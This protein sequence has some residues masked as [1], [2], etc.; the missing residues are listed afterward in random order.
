MKNVCFGFMLLCVAVNTNA[1]FGELQLIDDV[2]FQ[3]SIVFASDLD[4][5]SDM[6][7]LI[8]G[9]NANTVAWYENLDGEGTFGEIQYIDQNLFFT[10]SL[11]TADFDG[12]GDMDVLASSRGDDKVVWYENLDGLG[13]F[14][15]AH[16]INDTA[17][18]VKE[19]VAV[20]IDGD[21]DMDVVAAVTNANKVVWYENLDGLGNFSDENIISNT[22][23]GV[24]YVDTADV[25]GD[26][27]VD[28]LANSSSTADPSWFANLDGQGNF[29]E[30]NIIDFDSTFKLMPADIDNDGDI[31]VFKLE[32]VNDISE[33]SWLENIDG[34][35]TF[36]QRQTISSIFQGSEMDATDID[37]DGDIDLF[38]VYVGDENISWFE[39]LDGLG[40]FGER[41][42]IDN[43]AS[44]SIVGA[45]LDGDGYKD[46]LTIANHDPVWYKNLTYL[47]I[48]DNI[49]SP[50]TISPN[51]TKGLVTITAPNTII[52][53][54]RVYD[55]LG[56]QVLTQK[57]YTQTINLTTLQSGFYLI[58]VETEQ[59]TLVKK[60]VKQ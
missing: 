46:A 23:T 11:S 52:K 57:N 39:N 31:D 48:N 13:D 4:G 5:D 26:G 2:A 38:T 44:T 28:V 15:T 37:N 1:Q 51:P 56:K 19:V 41:Q 21:N 6:D 14:S 30:E 7:V 29:G 40:T 43:F 17:P 18:F 34:L 36:E 59:G 32:D 16:I 22:T 55:M 49:L 58:K 25:N 9:Q 60:I 27:F 50:I 35:G 12:D 33:F 45:D 54:V 47:S 3:T 10:Q 53:S 8:L 20:D 24:Y 42:T